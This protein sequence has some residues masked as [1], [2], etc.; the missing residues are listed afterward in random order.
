[1]R[2]CKY[3]LIFLLGLAFFTFFGGA[4]SAATL[5]LSPST[6][7]FQIDSTFQVSLFLNTA[8]QSV[9]TLDISLKFPADKLQLVSPSAGKSII[10]VWTAQPVYDNQTGGIRL[11]GGMPGGVTTS[12]G[13]VT[14]LT[15]RVK[16]MGTTAV[17]FSDATRVLANDGKGT[18]V[19]QDTQGGVY[20]L[21]LPP[22]AGPIVA[23]ETHSDQVE[24]YANST[25]VLSWANDN[26]VQGYSY[27]LSDQPVEIP[28]DIS[29][30]TQMNVAYRNL[31]SGSHYFHIKALRE[32][33]WGGT[34]HFAVN[35][36][37]DPPAEFSIAV[38]PAPTTVSKS[39]VVRWGT[40]DKDSGLS[41]YEYAVIA[42]VPQSV[43]AA[44]QTMFIE[45]GSPQLLRLNERGTYDVIVRAFDNAGNTREAVR[46]IKIVTPLEYAFLSI[47]SWIIII[48]VTIVLVGGA[49]FAWKAHRR[50]DALQ[51]QKSM[52]PEVQRQLEELQEYR[53]KYGKTMPLW[54]L[55]AVSMPLFFGII[56]A[57]NADTAISSPPYVSTISQNISN[58]EIFYVGGKTDAGNIPVTI[59]L[60][61]L[62]TGEAQSF[63]VTSNSKGDWFYRHTGFLEAGN[64]LL[65]VQS[66]IGEESSPPGPQIKLT[67]RQTALQF[68]ASRLSYETLYLLLAILLLL[69]NAGLIFFIISHARHARKKH[70]EWLREVREAEE[71]VRRGFAVLK[72]DINA[73]LQ[74]IKKAKLNK[75]L[76]SEESRREEQLLRDLAWAEQYIGKEIWDV[77]R[78]E[79]ED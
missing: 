67:V 18:D 79:H 20:A 17:R 57:T 59:Y 74:I 6:G 72:R 13:L 43:E 44:E 51:Q 12:N 25:A 61:N 49:V 19:L 78:T 46:R 2:D 33:A 36:D 62:R 77:E 53:K 3:Y 11:Q 22:P 38:D 1:M 9:N 60:Q 26:P 56:G 16:G 32:G 73:E 76:S 24:W 34:T 23:S 75:E 40:T 69:G 48:F 52:A 4:A 41:H 64:Y 71:S 8:E 14:T 45:A 29:E 66:K 55:L 27:S 5:S 28:D 63:T 31:S 50:V 30:G 54:L 65:W 7:T 35:V 39:P 70:K 21:V 47:W 37:I 42:L 10:S 58:A 68:G 15:F